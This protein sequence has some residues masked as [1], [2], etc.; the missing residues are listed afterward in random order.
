MFAPWLSE[1]ARAFG[2][3]FSSKGLRRL[4]LALAGSVIGDWAFVM[5]MLVYADTQGGATAVGVL[6]LVRSVVAAAA[7]PFLSSLA[8]RHRRRS[9]MIAADVVRAIATAVAAVAVATSAPSTLVYAMVVVVTVSGTAFVPA[10]TALLPSLTASPEEL[11]AANVVTN[12]IESVGLFIG[13]ALGGLLLTVVGID[14]VMALDS[15]TFIWSVGM[16]RGIPRGDIPEILDEA[17]HFLRESMAGFSAVARNAGLRIIVGLYGMQVFVSGAITVLIVELALGPLHMGESGVGSLNAAVGVGGIVGGLVTAGLVA[18]GRLSSDFAIGLLGWGVPIALIAVHATAWFALAMLFV[19][20]IGNVVVD[21]SA[22][23]LLQRVAPDEVLG[24]VFGVLETVFS[25]TYGIGGVVT[26]ILIH[27]AGWQTTLVIIGAL[28]PL[29]VVLTWPMLRRSDVGVLQPER[30]TLVRGVPF[31][32]P[33]PEA[34]LERITSLLEPVSVRAGDIVFAQSDEGDRFYLIESGEATV[35]RDG[36]EVARLEPGGYFGEI[37][38]VREVPRTATI[39]AISDLSLLAL[40][41]DEF[42]AAV[43]GH[44]PSRDAADAV[45]STRLGGLRPG[46]ASL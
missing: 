3:V 22:V 4:Q 41:R 25:I 29:V 36:R 35:L 45:I 12:T 28:L 2:E 37:A 27:A 40:D 18:R 21:V 15:A 7:A 1:S 46:L 30:L 16:I 38:L 17:P 43:T 8:D 14:W 42:I 6:T 23:T 5:A 19:L 11:T 44:A 39:R 33:L 9:V 13:P 32:G 24:R 26:S 34:T 31:L 20:G 10:Q